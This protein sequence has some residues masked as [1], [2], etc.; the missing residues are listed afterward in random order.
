MA[1][2]AAAAKK[3]PPSSPSKVSAEGIGAF[4]KAVGISKNRYY[5]IAFFI[6]VVLM[7]ISYAIFGLYPFGER[8]VLA[9]DFNAQ[10]VY[11]FESLRDDF[12]HF[13]RSFF[14]D[15]SRNLSGGYMGVIGY[16]LASPYTL[17]V[18]LLP[19]K[20]ILTSLLIMILCK[21]GSASVTFNLY[22]Q[23]SKGFTPLNATVFSVLYSMMAYMIIQTVDPMWL[24]GLVL[25]P[26]V[27]LGL[28][29]LIDDGRKLG[30]ILPLALMF[31]ANFYI[32]YMIGIFTAI[33]FLYYLFFGKEERRGKVKDYLYTCCNYGVSS[34]VA[35]MLSA[36]MIL[37]VYN[38][39]QLGKF[40]FTD[41]DFSF[42]VQFEPA[43]ILAQLL[44]AQYD[45]VN[46]QGSPEIYCGILAVVL[47]P[48]FF[49]NSKISLRKKF[50]Y[51]FL[52]TVMFF[53]HVHQAGGYVVAWRTGAQLAPLPLL[54]HHFLH[55]AVDGGNGIP[56][57][58]RHQAQA[59]GCHLLRGNGCH[60][61]YPR[62]GL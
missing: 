21:I 30:Y 29:H 38:A 24:D 54:L 1:N 3:A 51:G 58:G 10:Y 45:S 20:M 37:P 16:Y 43:T 40:D 33:Y 59:P 55:S 49:L 48:L 60:P 62:S 53:S 28:E 13:D 39:L 8:S 52:C 14:Y 9:L 47:L 42:Q 50:G 17:I 25:L 5:I 35:V 12:W 34:I 23:K 32:G 7:Y 6:P 31:V 4:L 41:P 18:M 56:A 22:L 2:A 57:S 11:Y 44:T 19:R 61:V 46:V 15:W 36:F 26:L 27:A